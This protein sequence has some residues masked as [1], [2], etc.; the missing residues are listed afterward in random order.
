MEIIVTANKKGGVG[1]TT[2]TQNVASIFANLG[3]KV[4]AIDMDPQANLTQAWGIDG[5]K[6]KTII[7]I[8]RNKAVWHEVA[9]PVEKNEG[10]GCVFLIPSSRQLAAMAEIFAQEFGKEFLLKEALEKLPSTFDIVVIDS[11][12]SLD[13]LAINTYVAATKVLIPVQ[14]EFYS[15]EG[16]TLMHDDLHRVQQRLNPNLQILGIVPT[17]VDMRKRLCRDVLKTLYAKHEFTTKSTIR[18]NVSLAEAPS[19]GKSIFA[20]EPKSYGA[21]DYTALGNE[22]IKLLEANNV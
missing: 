11:P 22:L 19:F 14:C 16:L 1:K 9:K 2:T 21:Q 17:F 15:L 13:L 5:T 12:P 18:D 7:D 4:L 8:L 20:Y 3:K 6:G 10:G